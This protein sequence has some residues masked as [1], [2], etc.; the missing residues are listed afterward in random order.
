MNR[1]VSA[2]LMLVILGALAVS[3]GCIK[4][5]KMPSEE[6]MW[7]PAPDRFERGAERFEEVGRLEEVN[8][9][10]DF[11]IYEVI[12][13]DD[14]E[15]V[16][17]SA[18]IR[19]HSEPGEPGYAER[20][21]NVADGVVVWSI[22][23]GR[24]EW[25]DVPKSTPDASGRPTPLGISQDNSLLAIKHGSHVSIWS[26]LE[27]RNVCSFDFM[28]AVSPDDAPTDPCKCTGPISGAMLKVWQTVW[29]EQIQSKDGP[30][31]A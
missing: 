28:Q 5:M 12:A 27:R 8:G 31:A 29:H 15:V 4:R 20:K 9:K 11:S 16:V 21:W 23:E 18:N 14:G 3:Q 1:H 10:K 6:L 24:R 25:V 30:E 2:L 7:Q 13:S 22:R 26:L 19:W 17:F